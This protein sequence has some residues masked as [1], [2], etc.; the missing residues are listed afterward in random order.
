MTTILNA[1]KT[2][3]Q[4]NTDDINNYGTPLYII[5]KLN[6]ILDD[7]KIWKSNEV[8]DLCCNSSNLKY[9][10]GLSE[11]GSIGFK[12]FY[13]GESLQQKWHKLGKYGWL[14]PPY[15]PA[16]V[17]EKFSEKSF[18]ESFY[19][20]I[21]VGLFQSTSTETQWF[22]KIYKEHEL[23][24]SCYF[25]HLAG[26][27]QFVKGRDN[28]TRNERSKRTSNNFFGNTIVIWGANDII[29]KWNKNKRLNFFRKINSLI[30]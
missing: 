10:K 11:N 24:R 28:I 26:R 2:V 17:Q 16:G 20:M 27:I 30:K 19:D 4:R 14:A 29:W 25:V 23:K 22:Q 15:S 18:V 7:Y 1:K 9:K 3:S 13:K 5:K 21:I 12:K 6:K 8:I